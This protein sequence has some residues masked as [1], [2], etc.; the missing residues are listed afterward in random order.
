MNDWPQQMPFIIKPNE[1]VMVD[2]EA[3]LAGQAIGKNPNATFFHGDCQGSLASWMGYKT[4]LLEDFR[5]YLVHWKLVHV[6][7]RLNFK[8]RADTFYYVENWCADSVIVGKC[9][10]MAV[11]VFPDKCGLLKILSNR[12]D[13]VDNHMSWPVL[14]EGFGR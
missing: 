14:M 4:T 10:V 7:D 13:N 12:T 3:V 11:V 5:I 9:Y 6:S 8:D 2:G 1:L